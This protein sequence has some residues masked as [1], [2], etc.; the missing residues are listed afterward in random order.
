MT[1]PAL[2]YFETVSPLG[3]WSPNTAPDMPQTTSVNG[4]LR[5]VG[6]SGAIGPRI[7]AVQLV[8]DH[9]RHLDL[10]QIREVLSPDGLFVAVT[11]QPAGQG[12][13]DVPAA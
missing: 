8:P 9:Y 5:Q 2:W 13:D 12:G 4:H 6:A 3:H 11:R 1:A 7:R 10:M